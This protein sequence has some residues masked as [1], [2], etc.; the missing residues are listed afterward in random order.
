MI[1]WGQSPRTNGNRPGYVSPQRPFLR[2]WDRQTPW[3]PLPSNGSRGTAVTDPPRLGR[4]ENRSFDDGWQPESLRTTSPPRSPNSP[5]NLPPNQCM[6]C[7][8]RDAPGFGELVKCKVCSKFYHPQCHD[9]EQYTEVGRKYVSCLVYCR[10]FNAYLKPRKKRWI[11]HGCAMSKLGGNGESAWKP[12]AKG[13]QSE[14][15][16]ANPKIRATTDRP[17]SIFEIP[18]CNN[19]FLGSS[20]TAGSPITLHD[21]PQPKARHSDYGEKRNTSPVVIDLTGEDELDIPPPKAA[22]AVSPDAVTAAAP[23][24]PMAVDPGLPAVGRQGAS[25]CLPA[26]P[27]PIP[28]PETPQVAQG[29]LGAA[30]RSVSTRPVKGE[31]SGPPSPGYLGVSSR[32]SSPPYS[33]P[34]A[35]PEELLVPPVA[36]AISLA[37]NNAS[38]ASSVVPHLDMVSH[39]KGRAVAEHIL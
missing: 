2:N 37:P 26:P 4:S 31:P 38:L 21:S 12:N 27:P 35:F 34:P 13:V 22:K 39:G 17:I 5:W 18:N 9:P 6:S 28:T 36:V 30:M 20:G 11:C 29:Q 16:S 1:D 19:P 15:G 24:A 25:A 14:M 10:T 7:Q 33:P 23:V 8:K 32:S 3:Q